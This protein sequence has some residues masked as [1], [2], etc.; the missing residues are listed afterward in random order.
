MGHPAYALREAGMVKVNN[1][2][3]M[4]LRKKEAR[5]F[6]EQTKIFSASTS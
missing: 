5:Q 2:S 1:W 6:G 4:K 3:A